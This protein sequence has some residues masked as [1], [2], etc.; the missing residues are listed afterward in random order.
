M[1]RSL[2]FVIFFLILGCL[3]KNQPPKAPPPP[4]TPEQLL[5]RG[6]TIYQSNCI[7]CHNADPKRVG[8]IGPDVWGSSKELLLGKI[9]K[10][11]YPQ[12]YTPKRQ[13]AVMVKLPHLEKEIDALYYYLNNTAK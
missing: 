13:T 9:V 4:L 6:Q 11:E 10:G 12:G 8:S 5:S 2:I 1:S 3:D 7:A